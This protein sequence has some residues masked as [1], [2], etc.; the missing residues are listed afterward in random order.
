MKFKAKPKLTPEKIKAR[1]NERSGR[2]KL[3]DWPPRWAWV[4]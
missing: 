2:N 4:V 3:R 1:I